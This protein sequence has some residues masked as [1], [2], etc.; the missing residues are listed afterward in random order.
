MMRRLIVGAA[1]FAALLALPA[2][3]Y[4]EYVIDEA[5]VIPPDV[6]SRIE[7]LSARVESVTPGAEIAVLTVRSL[8]GRQVE[9][10]A[11]ERFNE[12]GIGA[13]DKDNGVLFLVAP[14]ERKIRIEVGYGLEGAIPD[15]LAGRIMD[16]DVLPRFGAGDMAGGIEA[17]HARIARIILDEYE[18]A[19][20]PND[21]EVA[22]GGL[23]GL[24]LMLLI[25]GGMIWFVIHAARKGWLTGGS[26]GDGGSSSGGGGGWSPPVSSGWDS[27]SSD[28]GGFGGGDSGGGGASRSW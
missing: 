25:F 16:E 1:L 2:A 6:E 18:G 7:E 27:G 22:G 19:T 9:E 5:N 23:F 4:A 8:D 10:Y 12:L 28:S 11:E 20:P 3:A 17:G 21:P 14:T 26:G 24:F 13:K 15:P